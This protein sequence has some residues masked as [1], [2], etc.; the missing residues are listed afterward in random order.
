MENTDTRIKFFHMPKEGYLNETED[1][2]FIEAIRDEEEYCL[3]EIIGDIIEQHEGNRARQLYEIAEV[4]RCQ[5]VEAYK[6]ELDGLKHNPYK[7][8]MFEAIYMNVDHFKI[9]EELLRQ[10]EEK[11]IT[12]AV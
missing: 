10:Y 3:A 2:F 4:F 9:A 5:I 12:E 8:I 11:T 7:N 6:P 1:I